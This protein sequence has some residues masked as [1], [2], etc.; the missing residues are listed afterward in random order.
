MIVTKAALWTLLLASTTVVQGQKKDEA[1]CFRAGEMTV[2]Q[3]GV[4]WRQRLRRVHCCLAVRDLSSPLPPPLPGVIFRFYSLHRQ[5]HGR[6][7]RRSSESQ[8]RRRR[9]ADLS[10]AV[11]FPS[12]CNGL[13]VNRSPDRNPNAANDGWTLVDFLPRGADRNQY[14]EYWHQLQPERRRFVQ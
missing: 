9:L 8:P 14:G 10:Q 4:D 5:N 1:R 12:P 7:V 11:N 13:P 2:P 6:S 3:M